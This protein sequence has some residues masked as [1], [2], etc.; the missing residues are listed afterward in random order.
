MR[1][2]WKIQW[3]ATHTATAAIQKQVRDGRG[4]KQ[5]SVGGMG[6]LLKQSRDLGIFGGEDLP[7]SDEVQ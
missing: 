6:D 5:V 3:Y 1:G 7:P 4:N 2:E